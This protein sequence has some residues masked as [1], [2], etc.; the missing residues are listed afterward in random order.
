MPQA[1]HRLE[2]LDHVALVGVGAIAV[3]P[4]ERDGAR[5]LHQLDDV[6]RGVVAVQRRAADRAALGAGQQRHHALDPARQP[7][8][9]ALASSHAMHGEIGGQRIGRRQ[10]LPIGQAAEPVPDRESLRRVL[11]VPA[12]QGVDG[13]AP[14]EAF[15]FVLLDQFGGQPRQNCIHRGGLSAIGLRSGSPVPGKAVWR[16]VLALLRQLGGLLV[17]LGR[18]QAQP[19]GARQIETG[20]GDSE[21]VFGLATQELRGQHDR[22]ESFLVGR[23]NG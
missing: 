2:R 7:D 15:G 18:H 16:A 22:G 19:F 6:A 17:E 5:A 8:P 1:R 3:L 4:D 14:P 11:G 20:A 10:Q 9:D 23:F 13:V 12:R 21:T